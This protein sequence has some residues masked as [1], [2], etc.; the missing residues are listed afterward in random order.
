MSSTPTP[1][2]DGSRVTAYVDG[3]LSDAARAE[4]EAHL[5]ACAACREQ[6]AFERGLRERMRALPAPEVPAGLEGRVRRRIR[7]RPLPAAARWLPLA[8]GLALALLWGRGA[9]PFVAWEVAWDHG[10][11]FGKEHLPAQAWTS[12]PGEIAE[13]YGRQGTEIPLIPSSAGGV[14]LVGGRYCPLLDRKVAHLYYAGEK[15]HLSVYVVP[16]PARFGS[17]FVTRK[18]GENVRLLRTG[19]TTVALVSEDAETLDAFHRALSMSRADA[20]VLAPLPWRQP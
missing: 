3:V 8:A 19:G 11:C 15:R 18:S 1:A 5:A 16:G 7:R 6:E 13:W 9:A 12:D 4:V 20:S 17:S 10:H 14:E 2:C